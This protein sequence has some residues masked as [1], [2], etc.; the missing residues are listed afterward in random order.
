MGNYKELLRNI[1]TFI[2]DYDGVLSDGTVIVIGNGDHIR[3]GYVKDGYA[4]Q[5]ALKK[6]YHIAVISGGV[7]ESMLKRCSA[8]G[9]KD[10]FFGV[11]HKLEKY[12]EYLKRNDLSPSQVLFMGDDI[13]DYHVM[14]EAGVAVCPS[15]A[16]EEIK[17]ISHHISHFSGGK[18]CVRDI[19]EQVLKIQGKWMD[20]EAFSW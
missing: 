5:L 13:P 7:S 15:D 4:I 9:I 6:G 12:H 19:I 1:T 18:G 14:K 3:T 17:A 16:A 11:T 20:H 8:L 10:A 2:F